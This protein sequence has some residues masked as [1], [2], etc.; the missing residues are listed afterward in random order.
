MRLPDRL[1][2]NSV[3]TARGLER[4]HGTPADVIRPPVRTHFFT[5][6]T[7]DDRRGFLMVA[8]LV[9]LKR[10][11]IV[12]EAFRSLREQLIVA[13]DGPALARLRRNA[14]PNVTF[15]GACDDAAPATPL[16]LEPSADLP[17]TGVVRNRDGRGAGMRN[18]GDR[19]AGRRCA[20]GREGWSDRNPLGP[21]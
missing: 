19:S 5:P 10:V 3:F 17:V 12:V 4:V 21:A 18:P 7:T 1:I 15:V 2:A 6:T 16:P 11:D 20:G 13:G 14:P 9:T 8:R